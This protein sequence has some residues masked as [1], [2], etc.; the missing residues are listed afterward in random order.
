M[1][2][3]VVA[4]F[5]AALLIFMLL[6]ATISLPA[7]IEL[8][9]DD[10]VISESSGRSISTGALAWEWAHK[11]GGSSGDDQSNAIAV[12]SNGDVYVTGAFEQT[13]TEQAR[14]R[15]LVGPVATHDVVP[16]GVHHCHERLRMFTNV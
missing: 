3:V 16:G 12:D 7:D 2:K 4:T 8:E 1:R 15:W 13:A 14:G 5:C 11:A 9:Q 6:P 10:S